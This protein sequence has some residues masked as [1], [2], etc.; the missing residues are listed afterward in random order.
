MY[1]ANQP[2]AFEGKD[3]SYRIYQALREWAGI[4]MT[5]WTDDTSVEASAL[6][7]KDHGYLVVVNHSAQSKQVTVHTS[8]PV[9]TLIRVTADGKQAVAQQQSGWSL[10]LDP[11]DGAVLDWK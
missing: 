5:V 6:N 2:V 3:A 9:R 8:L 1:L 11:Y 7:A 4:K 10:Q